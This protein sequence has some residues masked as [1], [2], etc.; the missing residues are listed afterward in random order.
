M[1][2]GSK[3]IFLKFEAYLVVVDFLIIVVEYLFAVVSENVVVSLRAF[4]VHYLALKQSI[5]LCQYN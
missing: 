1:K 5:L 3:Y 4:F 2:A